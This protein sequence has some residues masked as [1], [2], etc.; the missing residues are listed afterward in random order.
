MTRLYRL[1]NSKVTEK[2]EEY[3]KA[4]EE[5]AQP[6]CETFGWDLAGF[7][8]TFQF[9]RDDK[10]IVSMEVCVV[11]DLRAGLRKLHAHIESLKATNRVNQAEIRRLLKIEGSE[12][13]EVAGR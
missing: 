2:H 10:H 12:R 1:P 3:V 6:V 5:F 8:P 4:W 9:W 7:D 11:A 13:D